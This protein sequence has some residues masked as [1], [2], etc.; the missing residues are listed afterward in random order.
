MNT[1]SRRL[2]GSTAG[3]SLVLRLD[4]GWPESV[5]RDTVWRWRFRSSATRLLAAVDGGHDVDSIRRNLA[6][7]FETWLD[8]N[9]RQI[10]VR[11][12]RPSGSVR[13]HPVLCVPAVTQLVTHKS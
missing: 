3:A 4:H 12:L 11:L 10:R 6:Y 9:D 8:H 2:S 7:D 5:M 1:I 13:R